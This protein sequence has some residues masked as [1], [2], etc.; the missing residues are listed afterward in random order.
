MEVICRNQKVPTLPTPTTRQPDNPASETNPDNPA[1][2]STQPT[3]QPSHPATPVNQ[4]N[5]ACQPASQPCNVASV[6]STVLLV[7][8]RMF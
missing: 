3:R 5:P 2:K 7:T 4:A 1:T 8:K 6:G